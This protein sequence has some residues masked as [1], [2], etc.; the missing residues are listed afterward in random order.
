MFKTGNHNSVY[1]KEKLETLQII[2]REGMLSNSEATWKNT[3]Q[4]LKL[5]LRVFNN[6]ASYDMMIKL[7]KYM[8]QTSTFSWIAVM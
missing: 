2:N 5:F 7:N 8:I 1:N 6:V 3:I 4:L